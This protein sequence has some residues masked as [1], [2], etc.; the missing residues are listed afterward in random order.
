MSG[1]GG[2][3]GSDPIKIPANPNEKWAMATPAEVGMDAAMLGKAVSTL[4]GSHGLASMVVLRHGKPVLEQY[5]NGY[6]KDTMH[7]MRSATKSITALMVGIAADQRMVS[8]VDEPVALRLEGAYPNAPALKQNMRLRDLLTMSSGLACDDSDGGSPGNEENMYPKNDWISFFVNLP[9]IAA[10]GTR[11]R[12]CTAGVVAL[13]RVVAEA[14]KRSIPD[15][16]T[17]NLFA[18]LGIDTVRW[19]SFDGGRQTDTGGHLYMRPRDMAR[20]GQMVLQGGTWEGKRVVSSAWIAAATTE[21]TRYP[22]GR[23]YGYLW[24]LRLVSANGKAVDMHYA[25]GNGG[26]IIMVIPEVDMVV[27]FTGENYNSPRAQL[28]YDIL[29]QYILPAVK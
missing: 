4:P 20:V 13:G 23:R 28:P 6:D 17:A 8:G 9:S 14:S 1:C 25:N 19:S 3:S 21:K 29:E 5:W 11:T 2:T 7:D 15:F 26:Q 10:P 16:A 22:D 27:V 12:Y 24:W 18:P